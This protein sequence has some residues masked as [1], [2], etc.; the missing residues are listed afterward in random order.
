MDAYTWFRRSVSKLKRTSL[1]SIA[2]ATTA[3]ATANA[4]KS[5]ENK[6]DQ[7]EEDKFY[8]ITEQLIELVKSFS[9]DTFRNFVLP[10][11]EESGCDVGNSGNVQ[12]DLSDWQETHAMLVLSRV[13]ELAQLR[14]RL[15]PRY[16]KEKQ[17]WRIYFTLVRSFVVEY[18]L[19][20]V[21]V[22]RLKQIRSGSETASNSSAC[23][24]EMSEA[25]TIS[26]LDSATSME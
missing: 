4:S 9:L 3:T 25:K 10:D 18:E 14:F 24:V 8:G 21:R 16:L 12:M 6:L 5:S 7:Q 13:K 11:E 15:C 20:A 23:E 17:F 22:A 26:S 19:H 2:A 1:P